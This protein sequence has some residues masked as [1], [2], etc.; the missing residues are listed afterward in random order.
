[1]P[2]GAGRRG[3]RNSRGILVSGL[4]V[5]GITQSHLSV[6]TL[7]TPSLYLRIT[8]AIAQVMRFSTLE[9]PTSTASA[10]TTVSAPS[11]STRS[12]STTAASASSPCSR[13]PTA[14]SAVMGVIAVERIV[15]RMGLFARGERRQGE[16]N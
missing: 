1:M 8:T 4:I 2:T 12:K 7:E 3:M 6:Q 5:L 10:G 14:R 13:G 11:R 9:F 15:V 16:R